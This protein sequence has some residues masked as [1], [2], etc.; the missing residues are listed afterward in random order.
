MKIIG[1]D[2]GRSKMG[3]AIADGP[4]AAPVKVFRYKEASIVAEQIVRFIKENNIEKVVIGVSEGLM[5]EES[6][7]FSLNFKKMV[8][9]P[10]ETSDETLSTQDAKILSREAG[11][12]QKKRHEMEDAYAASI[13]LQNFL[14][15]NL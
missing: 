10:V 5:G 1:I 6:K 4:L 15:N 8:D 2:Y 12:K 14:D 7:K 9:I 13:M 3:I 11:I